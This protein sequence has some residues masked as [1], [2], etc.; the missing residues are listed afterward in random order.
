M[1]LDLPW[2]SHRMV[3]E[4][5]PVY[6]CLDCGREWKTLKEV[7]DLCPGVKVYEEQSRPFYLLTKQ[8]LKKLG[9]PFPKGKKP[10]GCLH[11]FDANA[12]FEHKY[13][14]LYDVREIPK[15]ERSATFSETFFEPE[16]E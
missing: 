5:G 3:I 8:E 11:T 4:K 12:I 15:G 10:T 16:K 9:Y 6:S 1:F 14:A 2:S 7:E 13:A